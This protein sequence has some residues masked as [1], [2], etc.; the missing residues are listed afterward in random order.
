MV[1][2]HFKNKKSIGNHA[3]DPRF[4]VT[5]LLKCDEIY[6]YGSKLIYMS[7]IINETIVHYKAAHDKCR[8][9]KPKFFQTCLISS[10]VP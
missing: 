2:W 3:F 4:I 8:I 5:S 9:N 6:G 7:T 10:D 1:K